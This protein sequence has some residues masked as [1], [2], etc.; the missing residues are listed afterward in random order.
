MLQLRISRILFAALAAIWR[1]SC[2]ISANEK[3]GNNASNVI[4]KVICG[5]KVQDE[6]ENSDWFPERS[7]FCA[8]CFFKTLHKD[9]KKQ[10]IVK[11]G[12]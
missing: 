6:K 7:E 12:S 9:H 8:N 11:K 1:S 2:G 10:F 3:S 4:N 5:K